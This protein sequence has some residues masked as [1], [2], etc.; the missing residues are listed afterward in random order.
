MNIT[1]LIELF[2]DMP[3]TMGGLKEGEF[4]VLD[5]RKMAEVL[6]KSL[7]NCDVGTA[8][9]QAR[10]FSSFCERHKQG[11]IHGACSSQCP[12]IICSSRGYC[13]AKWAQMPYEEGGAR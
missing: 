2:M 12:L 1:A 11:G 8:E 9:E 4:V 13:M 3:E 5:T 6:K 10:R 7:R